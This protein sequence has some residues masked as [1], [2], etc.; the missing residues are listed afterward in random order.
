[1]PGPVPRY[2]IEHDFRVVEPM[3]AA[4]CT[5]AVRPG[6]V[7]QSFGEPPRMRVECDCE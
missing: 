7:E 5:R 6:S 1:M 4:A 3:C 2:R